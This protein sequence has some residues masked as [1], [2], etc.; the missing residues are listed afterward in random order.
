ML[1]EYVILLRAS[2]MMRSHHPSF[3]GEGPLS[4][5]ADAVVRDRHRR[6]RVSTRFTRFTSTPARPI[7]HGH[8]ARCLR[9]LRLS[10]VASSVSYRPGSTTSRR[11]HGRS[12][13]SSTGSSR[14]VVRP[15]SSDIRSLP[16]KYMFLINLLNL[17]VI[18]TGIH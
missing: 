18:A 9:L 15:R 13:S 16:T 3:T 14:I 6:G 11:H 10:A 5:E 7:V 17:V 1:A 2:P 4:A 8:S 12:G